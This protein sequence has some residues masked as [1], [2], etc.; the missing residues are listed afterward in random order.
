[1]AESSR[2]QY[3]TVKRPNSTVGGTATSYS[4]YVTSDN[5][6][7]YIRYGSASGNIIAQ[8]T[9][10]KYSSGVTDG[11]NAVGLS[12]NANQAKITR[13]QSSNAITE[14]QITI[15]TGSVN[16]SGNR[17]VAVKANGT[18]LL[19]NVI[20]D[21]ANGRTALW[22]TVGVSYGSTSNDTSGYY[23]DGS[24][25]LIFNISVTA[26]GMEAKAMPQN[27]YGAEATN[28]YKK[29][30]KAGWQAALSSARSYWWYGEETINGVRYWTVWTPKASAYSTC[31]ANHSPVY[32]EGE[33]WEAAKFQIPT[34]YS[35]SATLY[36]YEVTTG[37]SGVKTVRFS[38]QY[39]A[40]QSNPFS[41]GS[42]YTFHW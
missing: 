33:R 10:N 7:A 2:A 14:V 40:T 42:S 15:D 13:N 26:T 22:N 17:T 19:S 9:H 8:V 1:M 29:G 18:T 4:Y 41:Q 21:Y 39:S 36:C 5:N 24:A 12:I 38:V 27:Y 37:S 3:I 16:S 11:K 35:R 32:T 30:F 6:K 20:S 28:I 23:A 31:A 25:K 34:S